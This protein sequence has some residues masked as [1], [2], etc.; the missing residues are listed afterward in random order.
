L[1]GIQ[2][3]AAKIDLDGRIHSIFRCQVVKGDCIQTDIDFKKSKNINR[4]SIFFQD[5]ELAP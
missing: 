3:N 5:I 2:I 4:R 1:L